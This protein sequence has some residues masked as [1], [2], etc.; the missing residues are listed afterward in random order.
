MTACI[1]ILLFIQKETSYE[2]MHAQADRIYRVLTIDKALGTNNQ[3]VGI[4][5]PALGPALP[6][7]FPE[8][9]DAVRLTYGGQTLFRYGD[10]PAI[11][12]ERLR[13][14]DPN[15]FDMFD[16]RMGQNLEALRQELVQ[17]S[18]FV[19]VAAGSNVPGRTFGRTRVRPQGVSD[20]DIWIWSVFSVSP[21]S[22]PT[23]DMQIAQGRNF[24]RDMATDTVD[25]V[26]INETAARQLGWKDPID[27]RI[28]FGQNDSVGTR[29]IGVVKD[30]HFAGLHQNIEPVV[31][32][33][34]TGN[35]GNLLAA[36]IQPGR[37][38]EALAL[39]EQAWHK[40]YP[41]HPFEYA[42][43]DDEFEAL[44]RR[45][46]NTG[47]IVNV[48]SGLAIFIA[49]LG[50][51]GLASHTTT[52]RTKEIGVRKVVG[53]ST[54]TIVRLLVFDFMRWVALANLLAWPLAWY[55]ASKWL[56]GFAYRIEVTPAPLVL[57]S[58]TALMV[59]VVTV[60]SQSWRAAVINPAKALRYE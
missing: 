48:F 18:A 26:M 1:L 51:F 11:Y 25:A 56:E 7:A 42:F 24:R 13:S 3:R 40:V 55:A 43:L 47:Q 44:Y 37:I 45:D 15:F 30:F 32:F 4:T 49:C 29:V 54:G 52:Q 2:G 59:A 21:E 58:L 41:E 36:R 23:L 34:L 22:V 9:E 20:K 28:Y 27:K 38:P 35:P 16:Q 8:I 53:A 50:L 31:I 39:A 6:K 57:A 12:A 19:S 60:L 46:L 33:P 17:H 10:R 5:M 14:A